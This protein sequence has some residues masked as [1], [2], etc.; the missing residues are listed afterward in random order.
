MKNFIFIFIVFFIIVYSKTIYSIDI[1]DCSNII[2][3]GIE[4]KTEGICINDE[5][6]NL[7]KIIL[8]IIILI[9]V[10]YFLINFI[11]KRLD[12]YHLVF[13]LLFIYSLLFS[14]FFII[15]S[16]NNVNDSI[17]YYSYALHHDY[18]IKLGAMV[19]ANLNEVFINLLGLRYF[20]INFIYYFFNLLSLVIFS[21]IIYDPILSTKRPI[22]YIFYLFLFFH[23]H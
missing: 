6:N 4:F 14:I 23:L 8:T 22:D 1:Q 2:I 11:R 10:N 9:L 21:K 16:L 3:D 15:W 20:E 17:S 7:N 18:P 12:V 19:I 5:Y 13:N